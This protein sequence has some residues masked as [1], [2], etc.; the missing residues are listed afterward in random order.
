MSLEIANYDTAT[1][2]GQALSSY[3]SG[4]SNKQIN[5]VDRT[6]GRAL[7]NVVILCCLFSEPLDVMLENLERNERHVSLNLFLCCFLL[8]CTVR[9][10]SLEEL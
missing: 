2:R 10:E 5:I 4:K 1:Q 3:A 6:V 8:M 7:S 9:D